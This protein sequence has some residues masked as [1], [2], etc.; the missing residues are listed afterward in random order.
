MLSNVFHQHRLNHN[1]LLF[2][3]YRQVDCYSFGMFMYEL[4][5]QRLPFESGD[6]SAPDVSRFNRDSFI[7]GGGR[8]SITSHVRLDV[9]LR[10][11]L[12]Y[13]TLQIVTCI[14]EITGFVQ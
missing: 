10:S 2:F 8:P 4:M 13:F 6:I 9:S 3:F 1:M 11:V 12:G 5:T 14:L 7:I